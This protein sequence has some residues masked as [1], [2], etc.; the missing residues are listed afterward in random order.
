MGTVTPINKNLVG[1][2]VHRID[3]G[4]LATELRTD[5]PKFSV[6]FEKTEQ[7]RNELLQADLEEA[8]SDHLLKLL[9]LAQRREQFEREQAAALNEANINLERAAYSAHIAG[10]PEETI[11]SISDRTANALSSAI[12]KVEAIA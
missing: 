8:S 1:A 11:Y 9:G 5:L 3:I 6:P 12:R 10:L 2:Q 7:D 4:A